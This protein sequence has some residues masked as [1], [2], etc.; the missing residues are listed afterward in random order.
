MRNTGAVE[1]ST[2]RVALVWEQFAPY[3]ID[4]CEAVGRRLAARATVRCIEL[5]SGS[6][7]YAW[8]RSGAV[9]GA[10][11]QTLFAGITVEDISRTSRYRALRNALRGEDLVILGLSSSD[12]ANALLAWRLRRSGARVFFCSDSKRDDYPRHALIEF[13][14]RGVL[15][16]YDGGILA[17]PRSHSYYQGL[18]ISREC[19]WPGYDTVSVDRLHRLGAVHEEPEFS[20]RP[21]LF[22]GR[23][24]PKKGIHLLLE[25][26][27]SYCA[28]TELPRGLVLAGAGPLQ[29]DLQ[30][31]AERLGIHGRIRWTGFLDPEDCAR[32][33]V[34]ALALILPSIEEQWGLVVNE[35]TALGL[36]VIASSQVGACDL[37]L[38]D[39]RNG[40]IVP[41]GDPVPLTDALVRMDR[42]ETTWRAMRKAC[43]D[44]AWFG[45]SERFADTV[46]A[47]AFPG[48]AQLDARIDRLQAA[49]C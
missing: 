31:Q 29:A 42:D 4:R 10:S 47:I 37:L 44:L 33:M 43:H 46:E 48:N 28:R 2:S 15:R 18:G 20:E 25:A 41:T 13:L 30:G 27:A 12:P 36:P 16:A 32:E 40:F 49:E 45:D 9:E 1:S 8:A 21:F 35:A 17:G 24:I 34:S 5:A 11:K 6:R 14:K 23:F 39:G 7:R 22:L 38:R 3:H 26:Y 19:L